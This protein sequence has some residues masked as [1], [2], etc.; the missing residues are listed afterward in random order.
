MFFWGA[1]PG[2]F[3]LGGG[4]G[5]EGLE[6]GREPRG[7]GLGLGLGYPAANN[8]KVEHFEILE[9]FGQWEWAGGVFPC[10]KP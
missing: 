10:R 6:G 8:S 3:Q 4:G 7:R 2:G 5:V 1:L 9:N